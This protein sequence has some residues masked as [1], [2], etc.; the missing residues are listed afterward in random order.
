MAEAD[1]YKLLGIGRSAS[2]N[3]IKVAY[4]ELVKKYHPDLFSTADDKAKATEK[5][6]LINEAYAVL[7][8][9]ERRHHYDE[10]FVQKQRT[11]PRASATTRPKTPRPP[12]RQAEARR[13][14]D[15]TYSRAG[16]TRR[17]V[18]TAS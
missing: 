11:R 16:S 10:E 18:C 6:R 3:Q 5:L 8:S 2:A 17:T 9:P 15:K 7:G 12:P 1:F 14:R 13:R 4:R